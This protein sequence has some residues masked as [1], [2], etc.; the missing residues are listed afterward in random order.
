MVRLSHSQTLQS[1]NY[2]GLVVN[3]YNKN[4]VDYSFQGVIL[5]SSRKGIV[6]RWNDGT[7]VTDLTAADLWSS[8]T[9]SEIETWNSTYGQRSQVTDSA[10][11][12][13]PENCNIESQLEHIKIK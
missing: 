9:E 5:S 12:Q 8:M 2:A 7:T 4:G 13:E 6:V 10:P 11:T 3:M 1:A